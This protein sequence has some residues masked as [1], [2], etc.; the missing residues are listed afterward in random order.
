MSRS[1]CLRARVPAAAGER[2][3]S[4]DPGARRGST[5][6][7]SGTRRTRAACRSPGARPRA[8]RSSPTS[9]PRRA[10]S[11]RAR[12][13]WRPRRRRWVANMHRPRPRSCAAAARPRRCARQPRAAA[14][15]SRWRARPRRPQARA[16][17]SH[18]RARTPPG[19]GPPARYPTRA[20]RHSRRARSRARRSCRRAVRVRYAPIHVD[21]AAGPRRGPRCARRAGRVR[22]SN[23][24]G[25]PRWSPGASA[26]PQASPRTS[27]RSGFAMARI[28]CSLRRRPTSVL[29]SAAVIFAPGAEISPRES[30]DE[31]PPPHA[32]R[33]PWVEGRSSWIADTP[34]DG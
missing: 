10:R 13:A 15:G 34:G 33:R 19:P 7:P 22:P 21:R 32:R 24:G 4:W 18:A 30:A 11:A 17:S 16:R 3:A 25:R 2:G 28:P 1:T 12:P 14:A 20:S 8:A 6:S 9:A 27:R 23:H 5:T 31:E 29:R 26:R